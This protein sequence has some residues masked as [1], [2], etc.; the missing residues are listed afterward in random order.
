MENG[1]F[2]IASYPKS[3]NTWAR[4]LID[5]L[6]HGGAAP[7]LEQL[8]WHYPQPS[9]R[10][11]LEAVTEVPTDDLTTAELTGLRRS[12]YHA[13]ITE[14]PLARLVAPGVRFLKI[15][16]AYD[17][18]GFPPDLTAGA[19]Y[20]V[21]D[22]RDVAPSWANHSGSTID[23]T[24]TEMARPDKA[25]GQKTSHWAPN[26]PE[27]LGTWSDHVRSWLDGF[28]GPLL[29]I[30]Y[31]DMLADPHTVVGRFARFLG[32]PSTPSVVAAAVA[33]CGFPA[34]AAIEEAHGFPERP[35][36]QNRFFRQGKAGRWKTDLTAEQAAA[37]GPVMERLGYHPSAAP[38]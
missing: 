21:R 7:D 26:A 6:S 28:P 9:A 23:E 24:I 5:S 4:C 18:H 33:A 34:L 16:D 22:P 36:V 11:W 3:G 14:T 37:H 25:I 31:E 13:L 15:H 32:L 1:L 30:R 10:S 8:H 35:K 20:L 2:W 19:V 29:V 12:A 38:S 17:P 27:Q